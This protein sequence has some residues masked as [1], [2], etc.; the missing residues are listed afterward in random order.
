MAE[1]ARVYQKSGYVL[2]PHSAVGV[3]AGIHTAVL[4]RGLAGVAGN[5]YATR[6]RH[7]GWVLLLAACGLAAA[8]W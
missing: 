2:D 8:G 1:I 3:A 7:P 5:A 6:L 4:S